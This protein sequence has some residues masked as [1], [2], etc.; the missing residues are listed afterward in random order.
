VTEAEWN[1]ST[2]PTPMLEYLR[3]RGEPP[4]RKQRLLLLESF[5]YL[6]ERHLRLAVRPRVKSYEHF[7]DTGEGLT[8]SGFLQETAFLVQDGPPMCHRI[9]N[10]ASNLYHCLDMM[11]ED[12]AP[13]GAW[14]L[15]IPETGWWPVVEH[16]DGASTLAIPL[17]LD[18]PNMARQ[19]AEERNAY[20][21]LVRDL[22]CPFLRGGVPVEWLHWND[23]C[24]RKLAQAAYENRV[25]PAGTLDTAI[26]AIL[27]D[28]LEEAGCTEPLILGHLRGPGPHV[29]GC[30]VVDALLGSARPLQKSTV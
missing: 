20:S 2:D 24:V 7:A 25:M 8:I 18:D 11:F 12:R 15:P 26:L 3:S 28:A 23:G 17:G 21:H 1:I 22:F 6:C 27:A 19:I 30:F 10:L 13:A 16:M 14:D 9:R 5:L 29:R 4:D